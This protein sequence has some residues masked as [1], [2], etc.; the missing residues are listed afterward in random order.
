MFDTRVILNNNKNDKI[1][2]TE[3]QQMCHFQIFWGAAKL[4]FKIFLFK[5]KKYVNINESSIQIK[6]LE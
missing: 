5:N 6:I 2:T 3:W 4:V 1:L